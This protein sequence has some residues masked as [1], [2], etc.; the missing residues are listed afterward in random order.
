MCRSL[1]RPPPS[2][3]QQ[4]GNNFADLVNTLQR[5]TNATLAARLRKI[6][7]GRALYT[8]PGLLNQIEKWFRDPFGPEGG[9]LRCK[10]LQ[11]RQ[12]LVHAAMDELVHR[13]R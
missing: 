10:P 5:A 12:E 13:K 11:G 2:C 6:K 1:T 7:D 4:R 9:Y 3:R 8:Y